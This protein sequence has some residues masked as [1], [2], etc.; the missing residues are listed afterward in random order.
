MSIGTYGEDL[1]YDEDKLIE[2]INNVL[3][4][5][6][7][8]LVSR[9]YSMTNKYFNG[10]TPKF[11]EENLEEQIDKDF[12]KKIDDNFFEK[13]NKE[14]ENLNFHKVLDLIFEKI[15]FANSYINDCE[16]WKIKDKKRLEI[17]FNN[18]GEFSIFHKRFSKTIYTK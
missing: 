3:N 8:N 6:F 14:F 9:V 12:I 5:E 2:F 16:P 7:G 11:L 17:V 4:N 1:K 18:L 15:R 10:K 13:V